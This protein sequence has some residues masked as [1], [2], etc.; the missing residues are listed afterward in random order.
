MEKLIYEKSQS[1]RR[2]QTLP[3]P[4]VP[5][6]KLTDL[7]PQAML[8]QSP[9]ALPEVSELDAVRH[10][11]RLSHLNH[12]IDTGF[13]PLGSCTMKYNPKVNDALAALEGFRE[14]HPRQP[15]DQIQGALEV[16]WKLQESI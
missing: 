13:Y 9:P 14:L 15:E 3:K 16:M 5:E 4:G 1:G 7:I 11:V 8:R 10:F 6:K 2:A 12:S